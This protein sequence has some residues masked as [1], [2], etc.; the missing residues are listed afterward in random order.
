MSRDRGE[1]NGR[2]RIALVIDDLE[3]VLGVLARAGHGDLAELS[4]GPNYCDCL[5]LGSDAGGQFEVAD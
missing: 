1:I 4:V 2:G 5:R 3:A